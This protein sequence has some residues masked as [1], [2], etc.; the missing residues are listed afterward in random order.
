MNDVTLTQLKIVVE[1]AVRPVGRPMARKRQMRE[2]L[3][4]SSG[5][6]F[7]EELARTGDEQMRWLRPGG[8]S[9][10]RGAFAAASESCRGGIGSLPLL[11]CPIKL[12]PTAA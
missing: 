7:Q 9:A 3:F 4:A 6:I 1:R 10:I 12:S 11:N 8:V 5:A 2:E